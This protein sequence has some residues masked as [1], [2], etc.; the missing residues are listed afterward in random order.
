MTDTINDTAVADGAAAEVH[1]LALHVKTLPLER[2]ARFGYHLAVFRLKHPD[3]KF[4]WHEAEYADPD[5]DE[6]VDED[7]GIYESD[8]DW[9]TFLLHFD[10]E[11]G[12]DAYE[13]WSAR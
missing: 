3:V 1:T 10:T 11:T 4:T 12:R 2:I 8:P 5:N 13:A 6:E 9:A 7:E